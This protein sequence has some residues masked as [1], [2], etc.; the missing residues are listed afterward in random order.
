MS[1]HLHVTSLKLL[2]NFLQNVIL[3]VHVKQCHA[4]LTL[5]HVDKI[6]ALIYMGDMRISLLGHY[7]CRWSPK[8]LRN[9]LPLSSICKKTS[10]S[11]RIHG[12]TSRNNAIKLHMTLKSKLHKLSQNELV[13][14]RT[15]TERPHYDRKRLFETFSVW[16]TQRNII[17][18]CHFLFTNSHPNLGQNLKN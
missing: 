18:D 2:Y 15:G 5:V 12:I 10:A 14:Q 13:I 16:S 11:T 8:F 3:A 17:S 7:I 6:Q 9:L 4:N 1:I